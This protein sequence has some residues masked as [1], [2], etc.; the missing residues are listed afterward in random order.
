MSNVRQVDARRKAILKEVNAM[1]SMKKGSINEQW[2]PVIRH[3][4]KTDLMR[5]P[6]P[7]LTYKANN[8]TV[9]RRLSSKSEL[10]HARRAVD[11]HKRFVALCKEFEQLT[12]Q[13]GELERE[14]P[15]LDALKKTPKSPSSK[16]GK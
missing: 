1:R 12:E 9:S 6:Y 3:G 7:V 11:N 4:K 5:G 8:K 10:Q 2:F 16:T 15:D 13:L 14:R